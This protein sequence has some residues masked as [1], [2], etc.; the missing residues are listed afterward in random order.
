MICAA[1]AADA[2]ALR[3]MLHY[4]AAY[5]IFMPLILRLPLMM[6]LFTR[7]FLSRYA[8]TP[9]LRFDILPLLHAIRAYFLD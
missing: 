9:P 5:E 6:M 4:A 3:R 8:D 2:D 1:I 7:Y